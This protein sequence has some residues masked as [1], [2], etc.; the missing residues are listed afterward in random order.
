MVISLLSYEPLILGNK[1]APD[2][3]K[4][5]FYYIRPAP[6]LPS[7][8]TPQFYSCIDVTL[9]VLVSLAAGNGSPPTAIALDN[10]KN[11][12]G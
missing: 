9:V 5:Q 11:R 10:R 12:R 6:V 8:F 3:S 1:K 2:F 4:A 7:S